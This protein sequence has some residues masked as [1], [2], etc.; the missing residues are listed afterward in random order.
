MNGRDGLTNQQLVDMWP[1][2]PNV[3]CSVCSTRGVCTWHG[4]ALLC[5]TCLKGRGLR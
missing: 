2:T 5:D 3:R 1:R 4:T